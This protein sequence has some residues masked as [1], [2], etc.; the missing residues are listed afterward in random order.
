LSDSSQKA[1]C[2]HQVQFQ[3]AQNYY[4]NVLPDINDIKTQSQVMHKSFQKSTS[5]KAV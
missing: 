4:R 5:L 3:T 2:E 1:A